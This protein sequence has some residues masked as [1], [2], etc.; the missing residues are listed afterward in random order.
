LYNAS[1][2]IRQGSEFLKLNPIEKYYALYN[3]STSLEKFAIKMKVIL[4]TIVKRYRYVPVTLH[5]SYQQE[6][7]LGYLEI[8]PNRTYCDLR[9]DS[10]LLDVLRKENPFHIQTKSPSSFGALSWCYD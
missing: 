3:H 6:L 8:V 4:D 10:K 1:L 2:E 7:K 5:L 9:F